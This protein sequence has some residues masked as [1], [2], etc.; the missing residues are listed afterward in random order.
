MAIDKKNDR[1]RIRTVVLK[2]I[3]ACYQR[4]AHEISKEDLR[5]VL[6]DETWVYP[7]LR[8]PSANVVHPPSFRS[9]SN[10]ALILAALGIGILYT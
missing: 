6:T 3:G 8:P 10:R 5:F 1:A 7:F 9:I 4:K 2:A